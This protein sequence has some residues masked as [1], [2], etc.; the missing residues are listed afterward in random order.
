MKINFRRVVK[1]GL[2][3]GLGL[4][5]FIAFLMFALLYPVLGILTI[6]GVGAA[7]IAY[8]YWFMEVLKEKRK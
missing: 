8:D 6:I 5:C 3:V 1:I 7:Y 2:T 4:S